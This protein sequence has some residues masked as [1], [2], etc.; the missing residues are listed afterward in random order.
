[1]QYQVPNPEAVAHGR[2]L[3]ANEPL[4]FH[5]N[6]YNYWLQKTLLLDEQLGMQDVIQRAAHAAAHGCLSNA[7]KSVGATDTAA[8]RAMA[9][10]LF[11]T[12]GFGTLVLDQVNAEGGM[13]RVPVSHYGRC[14]N[15]ACGVDIQAPQS[16]FDAGFAAAATEVMFDLPLGTLTAK[17]E[18]CQATGAPEGRVHVGPASAEPPRAAPGV[19]PHGETIPVERWSETAV[20][21]PAI[22]DALSGLDL[23]GNEEGLIPRF[24]V[25][26]TN[27]FANFYN[28]ASFEFVRKMDGTGLLEA[29]ETL[30]VD[31]GYRC[32]FHTFGGIMTS[33]EWDAVVKPQCKERSDWVHGMVAVV[34]ALG[35]GTWRVT[36]LSDSHVVVRIYDDYESTGYL[37]DYGQAN[38]PVSYLHFGGIAGMMNLIYLGD[39]HTGPELTLDF[40]NRSFEA[41]GTFQARHIKSRAMGDEY[42]EI[43]AER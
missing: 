28:R 9:E 2:T 13:V 7:V 33:P 10:H 35:W 1:M 32:A 27:H 24:G 23:S 42:T 37:A 31:A 41:D 21:E 22:L 18:A 19:G 17:V 36:D 26:L 14:L 12:L 38:R 30:L 34:N 11:R 6:F 20:S 15:Q 25:M 16:F 39:I 29:G 3:L 4:V 40:Y 5:C 43:S 8:V